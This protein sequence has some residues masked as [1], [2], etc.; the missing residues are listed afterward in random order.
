[1]F[2]FFKLNILN[3]EGLLGISFEIPNIFPPRL[4]KYKVSQA[5]L[6]PVCPV[7]RIFFIFKY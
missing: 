2:N 3:K 5:P 6:K 7:I 1:M 4:S